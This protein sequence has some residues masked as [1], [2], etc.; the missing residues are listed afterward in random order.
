MA[1]FKGMVELEGLA[2]LRGMV[3]LEGMAGWVKIRG[4]T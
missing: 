4:A 3:G 1:G 2:G